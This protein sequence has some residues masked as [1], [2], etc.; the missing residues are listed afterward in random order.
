MYVSK[1]VVCS[2]MKWKVYVCVHSGTGFVGGTRQCGNAVINAAT[3]NRGIGNP[4]VNCKWQANSG[5]NVGSNG[6]R[7]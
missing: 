5:I 3:E 6:P 7:T 4:T 1:S 2:V